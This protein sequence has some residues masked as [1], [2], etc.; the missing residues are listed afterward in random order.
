MKTYIM[1]CVLV[2]A[3]SYNSPMAEAK[4]DK[5]LKQCI[6]EQEKKNSCYGGTHLQQKTC[7]LENADKCSEYEKCL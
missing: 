5:T 4:C 7:Q 1:A 6:A 2:V 3:A